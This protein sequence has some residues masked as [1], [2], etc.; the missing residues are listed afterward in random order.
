M[1]TT[2]LA[3]SPLF[4]SEQKSLKRSP[5]FLYLDAYSKKKKKKP[6][7]Q[8]IWFHFKNNGCRNLCNNSKKLVQVQCSPHGQESIPKQ[9]QWTL[10]HCAKYYFK[11]QL[12][13]QTWVVA[14][15][16]FGEK[17]FALLDIRLD[18]VTSWFPASWTDWKERAMSSRSHYN[19]VP[20]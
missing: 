14:L 2:L 4:F 8:V 3:F 7:E 18:G 1:F 15:L 20:V 5:F 16:L 19:N 6:W 9:E 12:L 11:I 17:V 10:T 13:Q